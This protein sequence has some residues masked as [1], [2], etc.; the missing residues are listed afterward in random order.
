M[1]TAASIAMTASRFF[2]DVPAVEGVTL[3]GKLRQFTGA[4]HFAV[5]A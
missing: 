4:L 1:Y 2:E 3:Q 5:Q